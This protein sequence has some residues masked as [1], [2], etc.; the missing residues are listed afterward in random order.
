MPVLVDNTMD[1]IIP[2]VPFISGT[3][4]MDS[5]YFERIVIHFWVQEAMDVGMTTTNLSSNK[6]HWNK[7]EDV[8][9]SLFSHCKSAR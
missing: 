7:E 1:F 2:S 5:K 3:I 9:L 4:S 8:K 6:F